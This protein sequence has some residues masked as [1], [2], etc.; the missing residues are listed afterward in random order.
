MTQFMGTCWLQT[1]ENN[2]FIN[3]FIRL[4]DQ[5]HIM[6]GMDGACLSSIIIEFG[7]K[8][9]H[10]QM[11]LWKSKT[12][13]CLYKRKRACNV[14]WSWQRQSHHWD[15]EMFQGR[16]PSSPNPVSSWSLW[17]LWCKETT[18]FFWIINILRVFD[19]QPVSAQANIYSSSSQKRH[20]QPG[21]KT[22]FK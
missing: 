17:P 10:L 12:K 2:S 8:T 14:W 3:S 22:D 16:A 5:L 6:V 13:T 7:R 18:C 4:T 19:W 9:S 15:T 20:E 1:W 11:K 21:N